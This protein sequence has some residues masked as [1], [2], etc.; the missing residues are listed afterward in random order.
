[1]DPHLK[2]LKAVS[3]AAAMYRN[4]PNT[5]VDVRIL[6]N[7]IWDT[8]WVKKCYDEPPGG[9]LNGLPFS[10][11]PYHLE[12]AT[13]FACIAMFES[14]IY[15]I[16]PSLLENVFAMSS[17][18]SIYIG[19]ALLLD[20]QEPA[21]PGDIRRVL[22][23]IGKPGMAF[24]VPPVDPMIRNVEMSDW[25]HIDQDEFDGDMRDCFESAS[26][27]L[28]FTGANTPINLGYSGGQD[29]DV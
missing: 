21:Y 3:T 20:P 1:M 27:H 11:Q 12:R 24:L 22:G 10:L 5:S 13:A 2:A 23:N 16:D 29:V 19:S 26:L 8:A 17:S 18:D 4:F 15:D 9:D 14:G 6:Q 25:P 28:S 7:P